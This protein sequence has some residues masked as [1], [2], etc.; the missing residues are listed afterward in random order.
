MGTKDPAP[1]REYVE[2]GTEPEYFVTEMRAEL[3]DGGNV[4]V[5]G[6]NL[7]NGQYHL[8]YTVVVPLKNLARMGR[9][10]AQVQAEAQ[11]IGDFT[12][13]MTEH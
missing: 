4:R 7:R 3:M 6:Y 5:F 10:L 12:D 11:D 13:E 8:L 9:Q 1:I 2:L